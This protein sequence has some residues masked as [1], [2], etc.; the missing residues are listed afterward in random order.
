MN[1]IDPSTPGSKL[2]KNSR[3]ARRLPGPRDVP[4]WAR[5]YERRRAAYRGDPYTDGEIKE[6]GLFRLQNRAQDANALR[7]RRVTR[8]YKFVCDV[9]AAAIHGGGL[10]LHTDTGALSAAERVWAWSRVGAHLPRWALNFAVDGDFYLECVRVMRGAAPMVV[11]VSRA[12]EIVDPQYDATGTFLERVTIAFTTDPTVDKNGKDVPGQ[13]IRRVLTQDRI[14]VYVDGQKQEDLGVW[15][16]GP[17]ALG[18]VPL[19]H[20]GFKGFGEPEHSL[21][22]G[23]GIDETLSALDS[24]LTQLLAIG[25]RYADPLPVFAAAAL[26]AEALTDW[27]GGSALALPEG[28][29][30]DMLVGDLSNYGTIADVIQSERDALRQGFPEFVFSETSAAASGAALTTRAHAFTQKIEPVRRAFWRGLEVAT[31]YALAM[32]NRVAWDAA[33]HDVFRVTGG[34]VFPADKATDVALMG[35]LMDRGIFH[36]LDAV[37]RLQSMSLVDSSLDPEEYLERAEASMFMRDERLSAAMR[38]AGL[39]G[40]AGE[41]AI[42]ALDTE[43]IE[44]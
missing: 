23:H 13:H 31:S 42:R 15:G 27:R 43:Q 7:T 4:G 33:T 1:F 18:Q 25:N 20:V 35:D 14:D 36:P 19:V 10:T 9:D 24:M 2:P 34:P 44:E 41:D 16:A 30:V 6:L 32:S 39:T 17:H 21:G 5:E 40:Q 3:S 26:D 12:P 38:A 8:D 28:A 29:S 11:F 22:A 37:K